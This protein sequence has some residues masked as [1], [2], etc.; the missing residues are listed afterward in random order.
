MHD[1]LAGQA[2]SHAPGDEFVVVGG[3]EMLRDGLEREQESGEVGVM[4]EGQ[5]LVEGESGSAVVAGAELD[6]GLGSDC[7]FEVKVEFSFGEAAKEGVRN[8]GD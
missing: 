3:A 2:F 5:G 6:E 7:A 8:H 4:K 1:S